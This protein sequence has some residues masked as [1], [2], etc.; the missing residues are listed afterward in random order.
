MYFA[1]LRIKLK[2]IIYARASWAVVLFL[3]GVQLVVSLCG[4]Y[5]AI[6]WVYETFGLTRARI[7]EGKLWQLITYGLLH[8]GFLHVGVN[9]LC[10]MMIG[11]RVEHVLGRGYIVKT[12]LAGVIGGGIVHL[13][14]DRHDAPLVGISGGCVGLL[15][16]LTTL[17]PDS[18]MWPIPV[19]AKSLG[20]GV[21]I[22]ELILAVLNL[23]LDLPGFIQVREIF[24]RM[25]LIGGSYAVGHACHFGGGLAGYFMGR[26]LLRPRVSIASLRRDRERREARNIKSD[27]FRMNGD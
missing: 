1:E 15:I 2:S 21:M 5:E 11:A 24:E 3:L 23:N 14:M 13:L 16:L 7:L 26:W 25:H 8:G 9:S 4:G 27:E 18:R 22:T 12:L 17:S 20:I 19:S 10:I 6:P